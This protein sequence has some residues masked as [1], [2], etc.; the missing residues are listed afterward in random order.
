MAIRDLIHARGLTA[1]NRCLIMLH[2]FFT[3]WTSTVMTNTV[4]WFVRYVVIKRCLV[5]D[6]IVRLD[7]RSVP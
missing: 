4:V 7:P 5:L 1:N 2:F 3:V 6:I